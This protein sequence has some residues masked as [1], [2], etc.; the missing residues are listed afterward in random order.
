[1][2]SYDVLDHPMSVMH[3]EG[4]V[5]QLACDVKKY[6]G[7][8]TL[9]DEIKLDRDRIKCFPSVLARLTDGNETRSGRI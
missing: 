7:C 2:S 4:K 9:S 6:E 3:N 1:M 8:D 5:G